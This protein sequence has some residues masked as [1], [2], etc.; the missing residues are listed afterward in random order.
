MIEILI[1]ISTFT[2]DYILKAIFVGISFFAIF[3]HRIKTPFSRKAFFILIIIFALLDLYGLPAIICLDA[4]MT[5]NNANIA[6]I[7]HINGPVGMGEFFSPGWFD[8]F[9]WVIQALIGHYAGTRVY[10]KLRG[11]F[12]EANT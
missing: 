2:L 3:G 6:N 1:F 12:Q 8:F 10:Q 9:V 7:L 11:K 5:I 4:T